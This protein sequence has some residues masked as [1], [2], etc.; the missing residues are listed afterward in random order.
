MM[1]AST[2]MPRLH[3]S[4][5]ICRRIR[6]SMVIRTAFG[7]QRLS[8]FLDLSHPPSYVPARAGAWR[9][10]PE[11]WWETTIVCHEVTTWQAVTGVRMIYLQ[12]TEALTDA[13]SQSSH[14]DA[15]ALLSGCRLR[16]EKRVKTAPGERN[17]VNDAGA[18]SVYE[19]ARV[20]AHL[21]RPCRAAG[22]AGRHR[23]GGQRNARA[24]E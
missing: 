13:S 2:T 16:R 11:R 9:A 20:S 24:R 5:L 22:R 15:G 17:L 4:Q 3:L 19:A 6:L 18:R 10:A 21:A 23:P 1:N 12:I 8:E 7:S 14:E